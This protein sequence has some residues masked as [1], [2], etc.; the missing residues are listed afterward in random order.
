MMVNGNNEK[1]DRR[2]QRGEVKECTSRPQ[3]DRDGCDQGV[4]RG[5]KGTRG[6][7]ER[8]GETWKQHSIV[9]RN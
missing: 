4:V 7:V 5:K 2:R 1:S 6:W 9:L 3:R 8:M